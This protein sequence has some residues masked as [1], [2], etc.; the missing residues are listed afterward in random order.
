MTKKDLLKMIDKSTLKTDPD[1]SRIYDI[2]YPKI[3]ALLTSIDDKE[4][5]DELSSL[6]DFQ[7]NA[8]FENYIKDHTAPELETRFTQ[9]FSQL[10]VF[11]KYKAAAEKYEDVG[12]EIADKYETVSKRKHRGYIILGA[13]MIV[14]A[15]AAAVFAILGIFEVLAYGEIIASICGVVDFFNGVVFFV[16]EHNEDL[17]SRLLSEEVQN[18]ISKGE[19]TPKFNKYVN[20]RI[21]IGVVNVLIERG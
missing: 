12:K 15:A 5:I 13:F 11:V 2:Y 3:K 9:M 16:Y 14:F 8:D 6:E 4:E 7:K 18:C 20:K 17:R 19:I 10:E 1:K 21:L